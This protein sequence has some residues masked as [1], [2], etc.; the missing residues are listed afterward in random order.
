MTQIVTRNSHSLHNYWQKELADV[1]TSV[2]EILEFVGLNP[3]DFTEDRQA[4]QLFALRVPRYFA[5]LIEPNNPADPLLKQVLPARQE[6]I[7]TPGFSSDPLEEQQGPV[8]GLLHKYT[9]RV[10]L[11]VRGGCA[12]NCRYCFRRHFPYQDNAPGSHGWQAAIDYIAKRPEINEVIFSGGDPLMANDRHLGKLIDA[13]AQIPHLKR[14]RIHSRLPVVLPNRITDELVELLAQC[15]LKTILV[16]HVNHPNEVSDTFIQALKPLK[17]R[18]V[19][20]LNQSVLLAGVNDDATTLANLSEALFDADIQPYYLHLLDKVKGASH[21]DVSHERA[22]AIMRK[23]HELLPG[24]LIPRLVREEPHKPS[25][26]P[27]DL[28]LSLL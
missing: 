12:I 5:S 15:R 4:K 1:I 24:F 11:I 7:E 20:L 9:N 22:V 25:K 10:L 16:T 13:L 2:D 19:W 26:T 21:F 17:E 3:D 28:G 6:F 8:P 18:G 23:L 14:L 27:Q